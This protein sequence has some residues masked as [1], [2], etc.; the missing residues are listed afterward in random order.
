M[1]LSCLKSQLQAYCAKK[2][3]NGRRRRRKVVDEDVKNLKGHDSLMRLST[4]QG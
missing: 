2:E 1:S 4:L 3:K